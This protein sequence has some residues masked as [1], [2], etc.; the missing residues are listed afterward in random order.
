MS[1]N[2]NPE[3]EKALEGLKSDPSPCVDVFEY[4]THRSGRV[5]SSHPIENAQRAAVRA[6]F[7]RRFFVGEDNRARA[8]LLRKRLLYCV[9]VQVTAYYGSDPDAADVVHVFLEPGKGHRALS[10]EGS[11]HVY[12]CSV[13]SQAVM[14]RHVDKDGIFFEDCCHEVADA[15]ALSKATVKAAFERWLERNYPAAVYTPVVTMQYNV[16][17]G[18]TA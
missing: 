9:D 16:S 17:L 1:S 11:R 4:G 8:R 6:N 12:A 15:T 5:F 7:R 18:G 14:L 3:A 2:L 10:T 13:L